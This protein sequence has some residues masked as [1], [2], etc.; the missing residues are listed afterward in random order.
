MMTVCLYVCGIRKYLTFKWLDRSKCGKRLLNWQLTVGLNIRYLTL[1]ALIFETNCTF[2]ANTYSYFYKK[3][4]TIWKKLTYIEII[5][6]IT[7]QMTWI[8]V[9]KNIQTNI[10]NFQTHKKQT[11]MLITQT[12]PGTKV[13]SHR[14]CCLVY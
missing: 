7:G 10:I 14:S 5:I 3:N 1:Y 6:N 8:D 4:I 2:C 13:R 9:K 11:T 12:L